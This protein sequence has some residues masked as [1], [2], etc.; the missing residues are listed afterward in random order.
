MSD[1][2]ARLREYA[3]VIVNIGL[4]LQK[5][6][7]LVIRCPIEAS[8]F[9]HLVAEEA[10]RA[11]A[12]DVLIQWQSE[13][14][15]K[16]RYTWARD[17][18]LQDIPHSLVEQY[19]EFLEH[20]AAQLSLV[21]QDPN[22]MS[23]IPA[24]K[25]QGAMSA[26]SRALKTYQDAMMRSDF[27]WCVAAVSTPSWAKHLFPDLSSEEATQTL[28][29]EILE[30]CR[31]EEGKSVKN[32]NDHIENLSQRAT[33]LNEL[34]LRELHY[35]NGLGTD[36][37][38]VLPEGHIWCAASEKSREGIEFIANIPTEEVFT[39]PHAQKVEGRVCSSMPLPYAGNL[40]KDMDLSFHE[41]T[42]VEAKASEGEA[43]LKEILS[44][45]EGASRLG[46]VALVPYDSPISRRG[47]LFFDTLYDENASCH[48]ALGAAYPICLSDVKDEDDFHARGGNE[49]VVHEDFMIGT[50]DLD[51]VGTTK[52][53]KQVQIFKE[54]NWAQ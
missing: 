31:I 49:S 32:W 14:F 29:N 36:L 18:V 21:G 3:E 52:D 40:I 25:I 48:L 28:W 20:G 10:Y 13:R 43:L 30:I 33:W 1:L 26:R 9:A 46:E 39:L 8:D 2:K 17:E 45:D 5:D 37:R 19:N 35:A 22:L 6:Q 50:K 4:N 41:G 34:D 54:G 12:R 7:P 42:V 53:G 24:Q 16:L 15:T 23:D 27:Q 38:I 51:I 11:G 47:L 44:T